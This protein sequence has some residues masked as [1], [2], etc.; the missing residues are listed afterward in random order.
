MSKEIY[1][2]FYGYWGDQQN[3]RC[4]APIIDA[5]GNIV[6]R[7]DSPSLEETRQKVNK[8]VRSM[9]IIRMITIE[10]PYTNDSFH[11]I[12]RR[13]NPQSVSFFKAMGILENAPPH[14]GEVWHE[15][16]LSHDQGDLSI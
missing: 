10:N 8:K 1:Y 12:L 6:E 9:G 3:P 2:T 16:P 4:F 15:M 11:Q 14:E 7:F 5:R 13:G